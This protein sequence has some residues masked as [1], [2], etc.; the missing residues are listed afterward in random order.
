MSQPQI[1]KPID[2]FK[3]HKSEWTPPDQLQDQQRKLIEQFIKQFDK[4]IEQKLSTIFVETANAF[5]QLLLNQ[6]TQPE[7]IIGKLRDISS[8]LTECHKLTD[9]YLIST[10]IIDTG[11]HRN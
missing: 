5:F 4:E 3:V 6:L 7:M 2:L 9:T 8:K 10:K 1:M 11:V